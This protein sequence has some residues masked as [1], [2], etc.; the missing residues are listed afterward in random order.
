MQ[1]PLKQCVQ[2]IPEIWC[3][4]TPLEMP[5]VTPR[6]GPSSRPVKLDVKYVDSADVS[7]HSRTARRV[8]VE[9]VKPP[10]F[11]SAGVDRPTSDPRSQMNL[12]GFR[13][14]L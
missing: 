3:P 5:G 11:R 12:A 14:D 13:V 2:V 10:R 9:L 1:G 6:R 7:S 4:K 8:R